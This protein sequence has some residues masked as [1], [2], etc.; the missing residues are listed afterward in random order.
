MVRINLKF[1]TYTIAIFACYIAAF[2]LFLLDIGGM[3]VSVYDPYFSYNFFSGL[4]IQ[5]PIYYYLGLACVFLFAPWFA[6]SAY[7]AT[8]IQES[9]LDKKQ[10]IGIG[11]LA[12]VLFSC[13]AILPITQGYV[14]FIVIFITAYLNAI[15][16]G[17]DG[18][19]KAKEGGV[20][21][22]IT[23]VITLGSAIYFG[24]QVF[25]FWLFPAS[26][27][28]G[29]GGLD[30]ILYTIIPIPNIV[31]WVLV[32]TLIVNLAYPII[33]NLRDLEGTYGH[34]AFVYN[35]IFLVLFALSLAVI[36]PNLPFVF[37]E[38]A[39]A[40]CFLVGYIS[41]YGMRQSRR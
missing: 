25:F 8:G 14:L 1:M 37:Y 40:L 3:F 23:L 39:L 18:F 35:P 2:I 19:D 21:T 31:Y 24:V 6:Y 4:F 12:L 16:T 7:L 33:K 28:T 15:S 29:M 11:V 22:Y 17:V 41:G 36:D 30:F 34:V 32:A 5:N 9:P 13:L 20:F 26:P 27:I 38:V 10:R